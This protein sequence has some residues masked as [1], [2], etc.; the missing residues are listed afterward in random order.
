MVDLNELLTRS[1]TQLNE[2]IDQACKRSGRSRDELT[3]VAVTKTVAPEVMQAAINA[4]I[5]HIGENRI[6]EAQEKLPLIQSDVTKHLI[7]NVQSNKARFVPQLFDWVHSVYRLKIARALGRHAESQG[8]VVQALIQVDQ[9]GDE[10]KHGARPEE[11]AQ[12][13]QG[14]SEIN[15]I[16]VRGLMTMAPFTDDE[17]RIRETFRAVRHLAQTIDQ[18]NIPGI[19]MDQLSMGM[20]GDFHIAI[21]EGATMIRVGSVL[22]G[23]RPPAT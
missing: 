18:M 17:G 5:G 2:R 14:M 10:G 4:G 3:V 9:V 6:Q 15:G 7:G 20:S 16:K 1:I 11:V 8:K 22:F 12:L 23:S 13:A 19:S 21:E